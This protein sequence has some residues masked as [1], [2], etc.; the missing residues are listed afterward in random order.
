LDARWEG[1]KAWKRKG[2]GR[3]DTEER[4]GKLKNKGKKKN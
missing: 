1:W 4:K 3:Q 2:K